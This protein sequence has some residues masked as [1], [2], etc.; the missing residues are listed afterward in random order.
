[1]PED[2][3]VMRAQLLMVL[4]TIAFKAHNRNLEPFEGKKR[5]ATPV[6]RCVLARWSIQIKCALSGAA[7]LLKRTLEHAICDRVICRLYSILLRPRPVSVLGMLRSLTCNAM[8]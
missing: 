3:P 5:T 6:R 2:A 1:M 7:A 4:D 8:L